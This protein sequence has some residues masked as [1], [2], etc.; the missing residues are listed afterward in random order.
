MQY[1]CLWLR[2]APNWCCTHIIYRRIRKWRLQN[3]PNPLAVACLILS[4][5]CSNTHC[6][7]VYDAV[8]ISI[9]FTAHCFAREIHIYYI[10]QLQL[11]I[12]Y[13]YCLIQ[14]THTL[15]HYTNILYYGFYFLRTTVVVATGA[16]LLIS[17][18]ILCGYMHCSLYYRY[19]KAN[20][21]AHARKTIYTPRR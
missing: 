8:Q 4:S 20:S 21:I 10:I 2:K 17:T 9:L 7:I 6:S 3:L 18:F 12:V 19:R 16:L 15:I 11:P 1:T 5:V 13:I 14:K